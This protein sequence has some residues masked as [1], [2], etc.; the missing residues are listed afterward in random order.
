MLNIQIAA[1]IALYPQKDL[2]RVLARE[3]SSIRG[4]T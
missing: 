3:H 4:K 2:R 1:R